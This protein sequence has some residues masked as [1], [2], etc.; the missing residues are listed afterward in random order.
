M[1]IYKVF[2]SI[3]AIKKDE[4]QFYTYYEKFTAFFSQYDKSMDDLK[5]T[6]ERGKCMEEFQ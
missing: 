2:I 3:F 5:T 6:I 1:F 4:F